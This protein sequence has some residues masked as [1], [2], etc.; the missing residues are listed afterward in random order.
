M[1]ILPGFKKVRRRIRLPDGYKLLSFWTSSQ[2]VEM[3]DGTTLES[4]AEWMRNILDRCNQSKGT[5]EGNIDSLCTSSHSGSYWVTPQASGNKPASTYFALLVDNMS[6]SGG[7]GTVHTAIIQKGDGVS[8]DICVR[9]RTN[10][11]W[12]S[13][14]KSSFE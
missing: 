13:W 7:T 3:D 11:V 6:T 12:S 4:N 9:I 8:P 5:Y 10:N 2:S 1:S 14:R